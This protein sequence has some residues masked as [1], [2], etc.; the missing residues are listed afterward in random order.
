MTG[1]EQVIDRTFEVVSL[2]RPVPREARPLVAV[3]GAVGL[4]HEIDA[5]LAVLRV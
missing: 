3:V 2:K 1:G 5:E 4:W